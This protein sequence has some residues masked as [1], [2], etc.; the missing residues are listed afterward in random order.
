MRA[1]DVNLR[2]K[3]P[4]ALETAGLPCSGSEGVELLK[5]M[6]SKS[7]QALVVRMAA[8]MMGRQLEINEVGKTANVPYS[9]LARLMYYLHC[10]TCTVG[11]IDIPLKFRDFA[12]YWRLD[13]DEA[14]QV[15]LI[16]QKIDPDTLIRA[17]VF[18]HCELVSEMGNM[19]ML[20]EITDTRYGALATKDFLVG[21][22]HVSC[23]R[24]ML[25]TNQWMYK[26]YKG[27]MRDLGYWDGHRVYRPKLVSRGKRCDVQ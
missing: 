9:D 4:F 25:Y 22:I 23:V 11:G 2:V 16:A 20:F 26:F 15:V 1:I 24:R 3:K 27:P 8:A 18:V 7:C 17:G 21:G 19:N 12:Q 14:W 5:V 10:V 13:S 6:H